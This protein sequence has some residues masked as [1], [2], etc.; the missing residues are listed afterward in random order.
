VLTLSRSVSDELPAQASTPREER[1]LRRSPR[2][3]TVGAEVEAA[4][5]VVT[6]DKDSGGVEVVLAV[7]AGMAEMEAHLDA[8]GTTPPTG[9][10]PLSLGHADGLDERPLQLRSTASRLPRASAAGC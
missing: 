7:A 2:L 6:V 8:V 5:S 4:A 3:G 1:V 10:A 9:G